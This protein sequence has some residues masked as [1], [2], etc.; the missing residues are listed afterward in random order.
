MKKLL[1]LCLFLAVSSFVKGQSLVYIQTVESVIGMGIG[2]SKVI[3]TEDGKQVREEKMENLYSGVGINFGNISENGS[4]IS[5]I[6]KE[7]MVKG[8]KLSFVTS[9][10]EGGGGQKQ[11]IFM[12]RYILIKD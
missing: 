1:V 9:A 4:V 2:R 7:Y 10:V 3:I 11:G 12:T 5:N 6:L 8:Y